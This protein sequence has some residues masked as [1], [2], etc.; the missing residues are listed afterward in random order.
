MK[1]QKISIL[2]LVLGV[3]A[4][5]RLS[6]A[7][8]PVAGPTGLR[9]DNLTTPLGIDD[10]APHFSWQL[11]DP[12]R[13]AHQ[14]AYRVQVASRAELLGED[15]AD[16][17]DSGKVD[18]S[19]S[20]N[21]AYKGP[22]LKASTRYWWRVT[23]WNGERAYTERDISWWETGLLTEGGWRGAWIGYETPEEA[24]VRGANSTW[25]AS[26][27]AKAV[28]L[29]KSTEEHFDYR[30]TVKLAGPVQ[31]A[32]LYATGQDAVSAWV[33]GAQV[34]TADKLPRLATTGVEKV[35]RART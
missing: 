24:A 19:Q 10:A 1:A 2:V 15:K 26:P 14:T 9:V 23:V 7:V 32:V 27:D 33:D 29:E 13:G 34:M 11:A 18:R 28:A 8:E 20:L 5:V 16:V 6:A 30:T 22:A 31:K 12:A 35:R 21:V 17:W 4:M 3:A 25:I